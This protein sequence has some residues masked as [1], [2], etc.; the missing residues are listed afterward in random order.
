M[1]CPE[2]LRFTGDLGYPLY[3][4]FWGFGVL[5]LLP[6]RAEKRKK[7]KRELW[8]KRE[9]SGGEDTGTDEGTRGGGGEEPPKTR[10]AAFPKS[11]P[12]N[13]RDLSR[14]SR[15]GVGPEGSGGL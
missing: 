6:K 13:S 2:H 9:N 11:S 1:G 15:L 10:G 5:R 14:I 8:G 3:L 7:K 12:E 4:E